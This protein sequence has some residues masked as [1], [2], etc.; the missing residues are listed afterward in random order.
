MILSTSWNY[1]GTLI[2]TTCKDKKIRIFDPRTNTVVAEADAHAGIKGSRHVWLGKSGKMLS[3]GF[4]KQSERQVMVWDGVNWDKPIKTEI[5]DTTSGIV[6]PFYDEDT[7]LLFLAGKGDGNVRYYEV[8]AD[9]PKVYYGISEFK[10]ST[11]Q[12]GMCMLPK[13]AAD[14]SNNEVVRLYKL[15]NTAIEPLKFIVPRKSD[16]FQE[17][18]FPECVGPDPALT[19]EAWF[20]GENAEPTR[21]S[22]KDGFDPDAHKS[23]AFAASASA[24]EANVV[25]ELS[26]TEMKEKIKQLEANLADRETKIRTLEAKVSELTV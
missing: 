5:L 14:V 15:T 3:V 19:G 10:S 24:K 25:T 20:A 17:D 2:S 1:D 4:T 21:I 16:M 7:D 13:R 26:P 11:P 9:D 18:L 22:L 12:R 6:M 23:T 8:V